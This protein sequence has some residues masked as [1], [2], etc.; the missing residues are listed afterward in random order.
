MVRSTNYKR[1]HRLIALTVFLFTLILYRLTA[2]SSV[3][4]WDCGEYAAT[5]VS[6]EVPHPPG[7]PLFTLLGRIAMMTPFVRDPALRINLISALSGSLTVLFLYLISVKLISRWKGFPGDF[8]TAIIVFGSSVIGSLTYAFSDSFWFNT[9]ESGLFAT[10]MFFVSCVTWLGL[11]WYEKADDQGGHSILV[12][13]AYIMGL[14]IGIHELSLLAYF[15]IALLVYFKYN[16][17][18]WNSFLKFGIMAVLAFFIIYP[19]IVKWLPAI[20]NGDL[21]FGPFDITESPLIRLVPPLIVIGAGYGVYKTYREHRAVLNIAFMAV[22]MLILGYSTYTLVLVRANAHPPINENDPHNLKRLVVYLNREQYGEQ[23]IFWPRRWSNDPQ[24]QA[25]YQKYSSD[26]DYFLGYQLNEMFLRYIGWNFIGRAGDIQGAP[27]VLFNSPRGWFDGRKGYPERYYA[28]PFILA[29]IGVWYH[30]K[31]DWKFGLAFLTLFVVMGLALVVYFNMQDPQ[32]RERDYFFIGAIFVFAMWSGFGVAAILDYVLNAVKDPRYR[33]LTVAIA[34]VILFFISPLNMFANNYYSHNRHGNYAPFDYSYN[35]LQSCKKNAILFTNGDNDTFP[36]WYLQE[37]LGIRTD[38]RIVNLSLANTDW[39]ILQLKNET[40]HGAMKV[41]ISFTDEEIKQLVPI[42][43]HTQI[44]KL[45][46][47]KET[48]EEFGITDTSITNKGYIQFKMQPTISG[49][50]VQAV[51]V[52]DLLIRNIVE[53]NKWRRPIYF[54][55]TVSP[56]NFIG[57][58]KYLQLQGLALQ[59]T[60]VEL[61]NPEED[62][63]ID[64]VI[65]RECL[66]DQPATYYTQPHYGFLFTNLNNPNIFYD[67]NVRNLMLNYRTS[68]MR[69]ASYYIMHGDSSDATAMLDSMEARIPEEVLPMDYGLMSDV[70]RLY[71]GAGAMKQF[72]KYSSIVEKE[73]SAA[74]EANPQNVQG[75]YNPYR[76]LLGLYDLKKDYPDAIGLLRKLQGM[77]P[78]DPSISNEINILERLMKSGRDSVTSSGK[79]K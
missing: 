57:L 49:G 15:A 18:S 50:Q 24:Y 14:S 19:G 51:R 62:F 2:Q 38:V 31:K 34:A 12:L 74:I 75:Y 9:V 42:E 67:Y 33:N 64:P 28:I 41:P 43:W 20:L 16:E 4:F 63:R 3:A 61:K 53:T 73:A 72:E 52:Q 5:S 25:G 10:S 30:F 47:P 79:S 35:I 23:P 45:P 58:G 7:A 54:A 44:V 39:Y 32:P 22:L 27:V 66:L 56:E 77:F 17:F 65:M 37:A 70:A 13:A 48:Y 78:N 76:V 40:P 29:L 46:V 21:K 1:V 71:F 11:V 26:F 6:L 68:F 55:A 36:L 59:L 8:N 69:L 60:P